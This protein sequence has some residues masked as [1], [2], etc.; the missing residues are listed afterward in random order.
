M[1]THYIR[2]Q[3]IILLLSV[4][5]LIACP[6]KKKNTPE[7]LSQTKDLGLEAPTITLKYSGRVGQTIKIY[8]PKVVDKIKR[9]II[10]IL[11]QSSLLQVVT[12][13][14]ASS[15]TVV[16]NL[17][18][19][20]VESITVRWS[21]PEITNEEDVNNDGIKDKI[22][23]PA[24]AVERKI[25]LTVTEKKP[26]TKPVLTSPTDKATNIGLNILLKWEASTDADGDPIKYKVYLGTSAGALATFGEV[27]E[28]QIS[29]RGFAYSTTYFWR[30]D[31]IADGD[32]VMSDVFSFT[33]AARP[34]PPTPPTK[35][36]LLAPANAAKNVSRTPI[37]KWRRS[38][39]AN[40]DP[41]KY[42]IWIG[43]SEANLQKQARVLTDTVLD[44]KAFGEEGLDENFTT[45]WRI[46]A[47]AGGDSVASDIFSFTTLSTTPP[48]PP[49][50]PVLRLPVNNALNVDFTRV[51]AFWNPSTDANKDPV[52]Y[53]VWVGNSS[54]NLEKL[55]N[56][57]GITSTSVGMNL[58]GI[59]QFNQKYYWQVY[60]KAGS[61]SVA[62]DVFNFTTYKDPSKLAKPIG[63][64]ISDV[65]TTSFKVLWRR[66]VGATKYVIGASADN[67]GTQFGSFETADTFRVITLS[68]ASASARIPTYVRVQATNS[69]VGN[70]SE[71]SDTLIVRLRVK[72]PV[73]NPATNI[74]TGEFT[75]SWKRVSDATKYA[76]TIATNSSFTEN[77]ISLG[78]LTDTFRIVGSLSPGTTYYVRVFGQTNIAS[79]NSEPSDVGQGYTKFT[80][81]TV[82]L[83]SNIGSDSL[84]ISWSAVTNATKYDVQISTSNSFPADAST[85]TFADQTG[86]SLVI[87]SL[88]PAT[89][90]Y[91]RVRAE[92]AVA[93]QT[94]DYPPGRQADTKL[95]TPIL[96]AA[97]SITGT[98][99]TVN[100]NAVSGSGVRYEV[101]VFSDAGLTNLV[102]NAPSVSGTSH[103]FAGL[104]GNTN[105]Y[106]RVRAK[107]SNA[108]QISA[109]SS[110]QTVMTGNN[111][112]ANFMTV[113]PTSSQSNVP[114]DQKLTW[115]RAIDPDGDAVTYD[116]YLNEGSVTPTTRVATGISDTTY[117]PSGGFEG[118]KSYSWFARAKDNK[119]D[120][121][122]TITNVFNTAAPVFTVT[123]TAFNNGDAKTSGNFNTYFNNLG[124]QCTGSNTT[125]PIAWS[126]APTGTQSFV[127]FMEDTF[128]RGGAAQNFFHWYEYSI[129][130]SVSSAPGA[131]VG[132][133]VGIRGINGFGSPGYGGPCPPDETPDIK[134]TYTI[135][136]YAL[137]LATPTKPDGLLASEASDFKTHYTGGGAKAANVLGAASIKFTV[138]R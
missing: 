61:D 79:Q 78:D 37:L 122:T 74:K 24:K 97:S 134:H 75:A 111:P 34:V 40:S 33:T 44:T 82:G 95:P 62:S 48:T 21:A 117:A 126:N 36:I 70:N 105:Y 29:S 96:K 35:P 55:K 137:N 123:S 94:S 64:I 76:L 98:G 19:A 39:D 27:S 120:S 32:T 88:A 66:V 124:A 65:T 67:F 128:T 46:Y 7:P 60:A 110:T 104:R 38:T 138:T 15:D 10:P 71:H 72:K 90:Y 107:N 89:T 5:L 3:F 2:P 22:T 73:L 121:A 87:R 30:V 57:S 99:F 112:P 23:Y 135:T 63:V 51:R 12:K 125:I 86:T 116:V 43:P 68:G 45:Y 17:V 133:A 118:G 26:P 6:D 83:A 114:L 47:H 100:W 115:R 53:D 59:N 13:A 14:S 56:L 69:G 80:V 85:R 9:E 91:I 16:I 130:N 136:V 103:A 81:P 113:A 92:S 132:G 77:R 18:K 4:L 42:F 58:M 8:T 84:R 106:V 109:H 131:G 127:I 41:I 1:P 31:A 25:E 93:V 119:G 50:K 49:T 20:G 102:T 108:A 52:T 129:N 54:S 11:Q 101:D 28:T